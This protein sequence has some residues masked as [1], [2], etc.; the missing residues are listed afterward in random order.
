MPNAALEPTIALFDIHWKSIKDLS[1]K[2]NGLV[3]EVKRVY[4]YLEKIHPYL[5]ELEARVVELEKEKKADQ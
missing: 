1:D 5:L 3:E 2:H 4:E